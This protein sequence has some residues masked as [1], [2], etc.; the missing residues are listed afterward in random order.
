MKTY[1]RYVETND[2]EGERWTFW[3]QTDGNST[4]LAIL[5]DVLTKHN[6]ALGEYEDPMFVLGEEQILGNEVD[7][8]VRFAESGYM[9]QHNKVDGSMSVPKGFAS[10]DSETLTEHLYKGGIEKLFTGGAK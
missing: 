6:G 7:V 9:K 2:H 8:L 4:A 1:R 10:M 5:D 3:L